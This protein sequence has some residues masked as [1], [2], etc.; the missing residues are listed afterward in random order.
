MMTLEL[1]IGGSGWHRGLREKGLEEIC[2]E[3]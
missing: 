3:A 1:S 2:K